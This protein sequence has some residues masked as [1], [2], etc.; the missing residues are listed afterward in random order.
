MQV[1]VLPQAASVLRRIRPDQ[2]VHRIR[3][4]QLQPLPLRWRLRLTMSSFQKR[5]RMPLRKSRTS[6][7]K[8]LE[9]MS[10]TSLLWKE[11]MVLQKKSLQFIKRCRTPFTS[12]RRNT[13]QWDW[14]RTMTIFRI[15][16][17]NGG[18]IRT[19]STISYMVFILML[20]K[21]MKIPLNF[22]STNMMT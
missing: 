15:L 4:P 12:M 22:C 3:Q 13:A 17:S 11:T 8:S 14:T 21:H 2:Q 9:T 1:A 5:W 19:R 18:S 7:T 10:T 6:L 16:E 20:L